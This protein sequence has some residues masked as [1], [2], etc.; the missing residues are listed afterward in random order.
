MD[1]IVIGK[2]LLKSLAYITLT[3]IVI[4]GILVYLYGSGI[5]F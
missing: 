1:W 3:I 4:C 5:P 2:F